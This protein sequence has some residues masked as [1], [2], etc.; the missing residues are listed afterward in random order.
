MA[1]NTFTGV[2]P[3]SIGQLSSDLYHLSSPSNMISRSIPQQIVNLTKLTFLYLGNNLFSSNIPSGIKRFC[4]LEI[5]CL[6][7]NKLEGSIPSEIGQMQHLGLLDLSHNQ[8]SGKIPNSLCSS[9][10]LRRLFLHH[11]KLSGEIPFRLEGCHK[12][13][14]LD[15][16]HNKLRGRIPGE[17][18]DTLQNLQFYLNLSWNSLQALLPQELSKI[19]MAQAIDISGNRLNGVIPISLGDCTALDNLNLSHNAFEG[20]IS[21]SLSKLKNLQEMD[22]S[23]N[24]LSGQIPEAGL[25]PNRTVVTL[26]FGNP[27]LYL[28]IATAGFDES[29]LLGVG[30]FGSVYKGVLR[31]G[32]II[33]IKT[34]NFQN[35]EA[36]KIFK[37]VQF[38]REDSAPCSPW[39]GILNHDCPLQIVHCDLK[40]S[41]VLLDANMT[42]LVTDFEYGLGGNV[43]T[44][45]D[46]YSY[47]IL[48]LEMVKRK[49][50]SDEMFVADMNLQ[51]WARLAFPDR[52]AEVVDSELFKDVN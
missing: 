29:N 34:L 23:F 14:L 52:L 36:L 41:N 7:G 33:A 18:I 13:E 8:L 25:F 35:E 26:I 9:Q 37:R 50:Q 19:A 11:N 40:P 16:S 43:S 3:P 2:L 46:V 38:V 48:I 27:G 5:F 44:K 39:H 42:A 45:G 10:Q 22:L 12:L 32:Q 51:K 47:G 1:N 30:N 4:K 28:V 24:N 17:V 31:D 15:L 49:R 21:N 20:P 6:D